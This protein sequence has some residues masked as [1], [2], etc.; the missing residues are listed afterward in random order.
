MSNSSTLMQ[1]TQVQGTLRNGRPCSILVNR[2]H[3]K[4]HHLEGG[5]Y[6]HFVR[7]DGSEVLFIL[8]DGVGTTFPNTT[9]LGISVV[10]LITGLKNRFGFKNGNAFDITYDNLLP[11][12]HR[13][14]HRC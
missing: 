2:F 3:A 14:F 10:G 6:H 9:Q 8:E 12:K 13:A 1:H 4:K 7:P 11:T 5:V